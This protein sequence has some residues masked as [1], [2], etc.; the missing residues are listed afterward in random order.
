MKLSYRDKIIA[1]V[2][3]VV[4]IVLISIFALIRPT[5]ND[6]SANK[7][8]RE[9]K[10]AEAD[11]MRDKI[12]EIPNIESKIMAAY[13]DGVSMADNF[14]IISDGNI[15]TLD[16]YKIDQFLQPILDKNS[17]SVTGDAILNM[18]EPIVM[19][20]YYYTPNVVTYPILEAADLNGELADDIY[21][22]IEK[23]AVFSEKEV[24]EVQGMSVEYNIT[25]TKENL[26]NFLNDI[27]DIK[28]TVILSEITIDDYTF[29]EFAEVEDMLTNGLDSNITVLE[30]DERTSE[31]KFTINFYSMQK[32]S[33][34]NLED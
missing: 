17:I 1:L 21:K 5:L 20:Y 30:D 10:T 23:S 8:L 22:K 16:T 28:K 13:D 11:E 25:A 26:L 31:C 3:S 29:K 19:E 24:Q 6:I 12:A 32:V 2:F 27:Q 9:Q 18:S 33:K 4:A 7:V 15:E 34:P 14:F